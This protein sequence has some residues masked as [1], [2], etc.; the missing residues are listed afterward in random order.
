MQVS[1]PSNV[2]SLMFDDDDRFRRQGE[3]KF[4][5]GKYFSHSNASIVIL[6]VIF[7][8]V[9]RQRLVF[10]FTIA[11]N[12]DEYSASPTERHDAIDNGRFNECSQLDLAEQY[13]YHGYA[14]RNEILDLTAC[15]TCC[16]HLEE[17]S[18]SNL[19]SSDEC[20]AK[21]VATSLSILS[22]GCFE[23]ASLAADID[24]MSL[25]GYHNNNS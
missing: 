4:I 6:S 12:T 23:R 1:E 15:F 7:C 16:E 10:F 21:F 22:D 17:L 24:I 9:S 18:L 13:E 14:R 2:S 3:P 20:F 5:N 19:C 11:S 25:P 8:S